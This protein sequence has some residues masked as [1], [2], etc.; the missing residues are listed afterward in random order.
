[1]KTLK[2]EVRDPDTFQLIEPREIECHCGATV[3]L[4]SGWANQCGKC[5]TEY[6]GSGQTLAPRSQWGEE[7][8]ESF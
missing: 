2:K 5:Q 7:T 6:N 3:A 8:G 1:M 4:S